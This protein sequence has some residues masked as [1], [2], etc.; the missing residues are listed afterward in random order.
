ML[1]MRQFDAAT[2]RNAFSER[3]F[4]DFANYRQT[5][6]G[7]AIPEAA[8]QDFGPSARR[9]K[10]PHLNASVPEEDSQLQI[11]REMSQWRTDATSPTRMG[12][13]SQD[14]EVIEYHDGTNSITILG[15][16]FAQ[17]CPRRLVRILLRDPHST[18]GKTPE[19]AS[20]EKADREYLQ[21]KGAFDLPP[22]EAW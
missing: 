11:C 16:V 19:M 12:L 15:E 21:T 9:S 22:R 18:T 14:R 20:L 7:E 13:L 17:E 6:P 8:L 4:S 2:A 10:A 5:P 1:D 3:A